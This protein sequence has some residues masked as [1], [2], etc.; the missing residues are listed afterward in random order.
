[1]E[2]EVKPFIYNYVAF[3]NGNTMTEAIKDDN[4]NLVSRTI[5][6]RDGRKFIIK[7]ELMNMKPETIT[8]L[9]TNKKCTDLIK[10]IDAEGTRYLDTVGDGYYVFKPHHRS[11]KITLTKEEFYTAC[12]YAL[13]YFDLHRSMRSK[14][15]RR[16]KD[17]KEVL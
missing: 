4:G 10:M 5:C 14:E 6:I 17:R 3:K 16:Y 1:M 12:K 9:F 11:D 7:T 15:V 13:H 8:L 2:E